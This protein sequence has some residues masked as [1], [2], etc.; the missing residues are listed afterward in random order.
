[1][2][3]IA[4]WFVSWLMATAFVEVFHVEHLAWQC[5]FYFTF[6]VATVFVYASFRDARPPGPPSPPLAGGET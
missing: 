5:W 2:G 1:M 4:R 6:A 3:T